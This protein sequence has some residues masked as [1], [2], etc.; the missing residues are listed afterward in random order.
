MSSSNPI[1]PSSNTPPTPPPTPPSTT[2]S[3]TSGTTGGSQQT[4]AQATQQLSWED[5]T[6]AWAKFLGPSASPRDV[7][8]FIGQLMKFFSNV[9]IQQMNQA[10]KQAYQQMKESIEGNA[11]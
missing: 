5:P 8:I 4:S 11:D 6:G 3:T 9:I 7:E 10:S 2:P 1:G